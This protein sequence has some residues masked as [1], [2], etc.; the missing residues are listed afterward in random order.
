[1]RVEKWQALGNHFLVLERGA[2]PFPLTP[3]RARLLCDAARGPGAD[4]VLEVSVGGEA[5]VEVVVHNRDGS[6]A[7]VSG[8]GTRIAVAYAAGRLG[9]DE[10]TVRT[11]A[12]TGC[13]DSQ[14]SRESSAKHRRASQGRAPVRLRSRSAQEPLLE[15]HRAT[16]GARRAEWNARYRRC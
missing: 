8:N 12:G 9:R 1:M 16:T 6:V 7:E 14:P 11:G 3:A 4:G 5:D 10:L 15:F 13:A 2:L